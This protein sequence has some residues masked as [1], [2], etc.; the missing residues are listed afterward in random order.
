MYYFPV[1]MR[2]LWQHSGAIYANFAA[3]VPKLSNLH[4]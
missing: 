2:L 3:R 1:I 4:S